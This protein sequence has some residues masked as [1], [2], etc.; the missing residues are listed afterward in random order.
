MIPITVVTGFLGSGK[1]SLI[2]HLLDSGDDRRIAVVINELA[3]ESIDTAFLRGGEH[4]VRGDDDVI[5]SITGGRIGAGK[6]KDLEETV[7]DLASGSTPPDV[8]VIET[9]GSS[10]ALDL[11]HQLKRNK[12]LAGT[13]YIDT[14]ITVVDTGTLT[15][16]WKDPQL[17]PVLADQIAAADLIVLNKYDRAGFFE[18]LA[19]R[20]LIR[21]INP[22]A[23]VGTAEFGRLPVEEI[24]FTGRR[25]E[26][27]ASTAG[28]TARTTP[29]NPN[30]YP[31]VARFMAESRPFHPERLDRWLNTDWPGIIRVKGFAWLATDMDHVYVIDAAPRQREV[32]MEGTWYAAMPAEEVPEDDEIRE[33]LASQPYGDRRQSIAVIGAPDAVERELRNIRSCLL[34]RTELDRGPRGWRNFHDPIGVQFLTQED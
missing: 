23:H 29:S 2:A 27:A 15:V 25:E 22:V 28:T 5:R 11:N 32:G 24:I 8:I 14:V 3:S 10:P 33:S 31:L 13:A 21:R 30:F 7:I 26:L 17:Q 19:A 4:I 1:T 6:R 20:R 9:S 12:V 18:R 34:S 16:Y